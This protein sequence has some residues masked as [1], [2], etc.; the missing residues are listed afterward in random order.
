MSLSDFTIEHQN[1]SE[2]DR[3]KV[4]DGYCYYELFEELEEELDPDLI[5]IMKRIER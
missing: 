2:S 4:S 5:D 1:P 3:K